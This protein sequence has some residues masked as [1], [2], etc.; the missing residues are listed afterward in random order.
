[1][2]TDEEIWETRKNSDKHSVVECDKCEELKEYIRLLKKMICDLWEKKG[3][4]KR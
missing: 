1:M 2:K 4:G 3:V